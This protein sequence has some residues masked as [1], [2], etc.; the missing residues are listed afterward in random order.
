MRLLK[1]DLL[2]SSVGIL[3]DVNAL[4]RSVELSAADCVIT[5]NGILLFRNYAANAC[6][7]AINEVNR[8]V[9]FGR[10]RTCGHYLDSNGAGTFCYAA[11]YRLTENGRTTITCTYRCS[12]TTSVPF[13]Q[14]QVCISTGSQAFSRIRNIVANVADRRFTFAEAASLETSCRNSVNRKFN[15]ESS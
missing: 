8:D 9:S 14:C 6:L 7:T 2:G 1:D 10:S 13:S 5:Y 11:D 4:L 12:N 15:I 3:N